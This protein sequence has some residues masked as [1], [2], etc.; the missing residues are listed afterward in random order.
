MSSHRYFLLLPPVTFM[1]LNFSSWSPLW[2]CFLPLRLWSPCCVS[3]TGDA[4]VL[5]LPCLFLGLQSTE[6]LSYLLTELT[7]NW[8]IK[9]SLKYSITHSL[10]CFVLPQKHD[11]YQNWSLFPSAFKTRPQC[12]FAA[13]VLQLLAKP[14]CLLAKAQ[15]DRPVTPLCMPRCTGR[16][17][18]YIWLHPRV[19]TNEQLLAITEED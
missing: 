1:Q 12:I 2:L 7:A 13:S 18:I 5:Y 19:Q 8:R 11:T 3:W 14:G 6:T 17:F 10:S 16:V 9:L 15:C 4:L